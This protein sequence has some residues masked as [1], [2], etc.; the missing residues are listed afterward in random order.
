[1]TFVLEPGTDLAKNRRFGAKVF[2]S[3]QCSRQSRPSGVMNLDAFQ[4]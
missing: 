4:K 3:R 2:C 1:M